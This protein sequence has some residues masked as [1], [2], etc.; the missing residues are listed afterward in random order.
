[1]AN[2]AFQRILGNLSNNPNVKNLVS[3][4]EKLSKELK[5]QRSKLNTRL[6]AEKA[7]ALRKAHTQYKKILSLTGRS[8]QDLERELAK[9]LT[10]IRRSAADVEKNLQYY[11]SKAK[12]QSRKLEKLIRVKAAQESKAAQ[13]KAAKAKKAQRTTKKRR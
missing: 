11:R 6:H 9:A 7:E 4:L 5:N 3:D 1:M 2:T 12:E 13:P 10:L 8:E